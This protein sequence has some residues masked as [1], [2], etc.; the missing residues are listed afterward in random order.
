MATRNTP[1][2]EVRIIGGRWKRTKLP[3][4]DKPGLRP[5]PDRVRETLFNWLGQDL[6]G[7]R[8]VDAFAGTGAL[9]LEAASRGAADVLLVEQDPQLVEGL[10]KLQAR[11]EDA[12]AVRIQRANGLSVLAGLPPASVDLVFLDPPFEADLFAKALKAA[13]P[14]LAPGGLVYLEA[15]AH[16]D[17]SKLGAYGLGVRRHLKAGSV[18]AHLLE[19]HN[20]VQQKD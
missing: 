10:R 14:A 3:V 2:N 7:W 6:G 12:G 11:L 16:W 4:A 1:A 17:D 5:T 13:V 8:C 19:L 20:A 9:G 18:H 15:P